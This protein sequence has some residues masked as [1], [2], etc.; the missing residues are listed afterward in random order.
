MEKL[1]KMRAAYS[2]CFIIS[3]CWPICLQLMG[4]QQKALFQA[5]A[6]QFA[7]LVQLLLTESRILVGI[8]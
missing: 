3:H 4:R 6:E 1:L 8:G 7:L 2:L 5:Q